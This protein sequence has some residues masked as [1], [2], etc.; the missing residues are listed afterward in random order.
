MPEL[1]PNNLQNSISKESRKRLSSLR[2]SRAAWMRGNIRQS[3]EETVI[4]IL[5]THTLPDVTADDVIT[6]LWTEY[7]ES[8]R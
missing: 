2:R 3:L 8:S 7:Q 6:E 1:T 4:S 5:H